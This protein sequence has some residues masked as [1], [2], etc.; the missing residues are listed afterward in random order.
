MCQTNLFSTHTMTFCVSA[1]VEI[2]SLN[3]QTTAAGELMRFLLCARLIAAQPPPNAKACYGL[4]PCYRLCCSS[5]QCATLVGSPHPSPCGLHPDP[6]YRLHRI[7]TTLQVGQ[8][9]N[10][11][12][13][14]NKLSVFLS[15]KCLNPEHTYYK[16]SFFASFP[17]V[18][19]G[20]T[21]QPPP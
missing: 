5:A 20:F 9:H 8:K 18:A 3:C 21:T 14:G 6:L 12:F 17:S 7:C 19:S 15:V 4:C 11:V 2:F 16:Y 10:L 13:I 1:S